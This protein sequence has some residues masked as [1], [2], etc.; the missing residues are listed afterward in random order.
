[1]IFKNVAPVIRL[2]KL[3]VTDWVPLP[4]YLNIGFSYIQNPRF[5]QKMGLCKSRFDDFWHKMK[6]SLVRIALPS[7]RFVNPNYPGFGP[8]R[9]LICMYQFNIVH[10][11]IQN[12]PTLSSRRF[13]VDVLL[14]RIYWKKFQ[15]MCLSYL[16][17]QS[18][19]SKKN[20]LREPDT[21]SY[22]LLKKLH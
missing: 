16:S 22:K 17:V 1:M 5:G 10:L 11:F 6:K 15:K 8:V 7:W 4:E 2:S 21:V 12:R 3:V 9:M 19:F 13:E 20:C 18:M 14:L